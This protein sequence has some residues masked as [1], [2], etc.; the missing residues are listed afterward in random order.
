M[1]SAVVLWTV[2]S[3]SLFLGISVAQEFGKAKQEG[4][5]GFYTSWGPGD[6]DYVVKAFEKKYAPSEW[7]SAGRAAREP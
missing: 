3:V 7:K 2:L 5:I 6:A 4:R 1:R